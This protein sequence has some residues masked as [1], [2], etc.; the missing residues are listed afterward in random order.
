M[1][2][3]KSITKQEVN[4]KDHPNFDV[5]KYFEVF[6]N[7]IT[8]EGNSDEYANMSYLSYILFKQKF[9]KYEMNLF[10]HLKYKYLPYA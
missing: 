2:N 4:S 1:E 7:L 10:N 8:L 3:L 9:N 6:E 5:E